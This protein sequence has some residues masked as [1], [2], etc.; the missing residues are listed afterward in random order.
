MKKIGVDDMLELK[1]VTYF[2]KSQKDKVVL[3]KISYR[4]EKG[5]LY[6]ILGASGGGKTCHF[7]QGWISLL[8][9]K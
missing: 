6:A 5:K 9:E 8:R 3:D 4:F 7:W 2:Y 1:D